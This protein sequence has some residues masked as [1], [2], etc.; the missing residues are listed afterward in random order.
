MFGQ[1]CWVHADVMKWKH[2]PLYWPFVRG[3]HPWPDEFP[4]QRPVTRSFDVFFDLRL[5]K[6]LSKQCLSVCLSSQNIWGWLFNALLDCFTFLKL[7]TAKVCALGVLLVMLCSHGVSLTRSLTHGSK[8]M[9]SCVRINYIAGLILDL[10]PANTRCRYNATPPLTG[11]GQ[12]WNRPCI[13]FLVK[14]C[15]QW[16]IPIVNCFPPVTPP[17]NEEFLEALYD[18]C[19]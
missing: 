12:T 6:P 4:S 16:H 13:A 11:W 15:N 9:V 17:Q 1:Y 10:H 19:K 14:I 3:I 5:N 7:G 18:E 2:F 8:P